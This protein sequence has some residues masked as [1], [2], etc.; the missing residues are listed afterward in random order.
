MLPPEVIRQ[1]LSIRTQILQ[2]WYAIKDQEHLEIEL[3][4]WD[5][6]DYENAADHRRIK[7]VG[8]AEQAIV[9]LG[10]FLNSFNGWKFR[11]L[12]TERV[13]LVQK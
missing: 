5:G 3:L 4:G 9:F 2:E 13:I 8:H 6:A 12:R 10:S 7:F 11:L 1:Q